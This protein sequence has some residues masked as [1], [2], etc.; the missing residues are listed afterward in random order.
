MASTPDTVSGA[1][2]AMVPYWNKIDAIL[3]GTDAMREATEYLPKFPLETDAD[4]EYR[5][6]TAPFTNVFRDIVENLSAKPFARTCQIKDDTASARMKELAA[7]VDGRGNNL[8]VFAATTFY[9][10]IT[11][12]VDWILVDHPKTPTNITVAKEK[13]IG[14][15]PYWVRIKARNMLAVYLS[16]I[17]GREEVVH[18]RILERSTRRVGFE[19]E[20][21]ERVRVLN[22]DEL[23]STDVET[24]MPTT[25]YGPA[26]WELY[27][28][29]SEIVGASRRKKTTWVIVD[30]GIFSIGVIPLV[31]F[32]TGRRLK[33]EFVL[34]PI[35]SDAADVQIEHFQQETG[36]KA[37]PEGQNR[38]SAASAQED[39]GG[40]P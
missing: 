3:S 6:T 34:N 28:K 25:S 39:D 24:G 33:G 26:T 15:R 9:N 22:R 21:V 4:Y 17:N 7:D 12:A 16:N 2:E 40:L 5:R 29:R 18:A 23:I 27:E 11:H 8:H 14:A 19:E 32:V 30:S 36:L 20:T 1:Y 38:R 10:G 37:A 35:M 31:P 13:A